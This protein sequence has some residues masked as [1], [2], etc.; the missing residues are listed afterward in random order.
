MNVAK[1][2]LVEEKEQQTIKKAVIWGF[3]VLYD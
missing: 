3:V 1:I 2:T